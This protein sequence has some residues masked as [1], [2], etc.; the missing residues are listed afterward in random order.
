MAATQHK[1]VHGDTLS[2]LAEHYY[3]SASEANINKIMEANSDVLSDPDKLPVETGPFDAHGKGQ[4]VW[5]DI[6]E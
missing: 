5:L 1:V 3:G 6:P 2:A 4:E